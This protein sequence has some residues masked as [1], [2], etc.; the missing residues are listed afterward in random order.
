MERE[1]E[2]KMKANQKQT[3]EVAVVKVKLEKNINRSE[4]DQWTGG[5]DNAL[6]QLSVSGKATEDRNPERRLKAAYKA[7]EEVNLPAVKLEKPGL[8]LSQYK[9]MV[10]KSWQSSPENPMNKLKA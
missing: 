7:Y 10:F 1:K 3:D 4:S 6:Q 9:Q 8:K 2:E 5:I